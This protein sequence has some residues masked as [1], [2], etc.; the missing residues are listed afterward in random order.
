MK[1][2]IS[3]LLVALTL[4][5]LVACTSTSLKDAEN[6]TLYRDDVVDFNLY[7]PE[8]WI[9]DSTSFVVSA[10]AGKDDPSTVIM[11]QTDLPGGEQIISEIFDN[12]LKNISAIYDRPDTGYTVE[13]TK[14]AGEDAEIRTYTVIDR[15]TGTTLKYMQCLFIKDFVLYTFTYY[16]PAD[17][18]YDKHLETAKK[19][20]YAVSFGKSNPPEGMKAAVS[21]GT[22]YVDSS[23]FTIQ[24]PDDWTVDTS[25]GFFTAMAASGDQSNLSVMRA[26]VDKDGNAVSYY[27]Q[28]E[29]SL[30]NLEKFKLEERK[31]DIIVKDN[32]GNSYNAV[33]VTYT[34]TVSGMNYY[35]KQLFCQKDTTMYIV[36]FSSPDAFYET[37]K[38][39]FE[40]AFTSF[41]LNVK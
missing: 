24:I 9:V 19:M 32:K 10:H 27:E 4:L 11:T 3:I 7:V 20:L 31:D 35:F 14:V 1:K 5:S 29:A 23:D 6:N 15:V 12:T 22:R 2:I 34:A 41:A 16:A 26:T 37:H 40:K 36:T 33:S 13:D 39:S 30:K 18:L 8:S 17:T 25:T 38:E 21:A 28:N